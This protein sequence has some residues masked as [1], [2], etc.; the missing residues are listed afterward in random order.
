MS[1][2]ALATSSL[3]I[4]AV[5]PTCTETALRPLAT[6]ATLLHTQRSTFTASSDPL[7]SV[8]VALKA[9]RNREELVIV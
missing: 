8:L 2:T 4:V 9:S 7:E 3:S 5:H 6:R 1:L